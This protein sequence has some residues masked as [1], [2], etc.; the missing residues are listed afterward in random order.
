M[1][2]C[3]KMGQPFI[4]GFRLLS[5]ALEADYA[6]VGD[7]FIQ[8]LGWSISATKEQGVGVS[9][10]P[11]SF[12]TVAESRTSAH[13]CEAWLDQWFVSISR[14]IFPRVISMTLGAVSFE[15]ADSASIVRTPAAA[16]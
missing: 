1:P 13:N 3:G 8:A 4:T 15:S 9:R 10:N 5:R 7:R 14:S 2:G 11:F 16:W 12:V 6:A